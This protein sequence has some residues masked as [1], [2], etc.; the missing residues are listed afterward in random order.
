MG[1]LRFPLYLTF[2]YPAIIFLTIIIAI[3]SL[4]L[5]LAGCAVWKGRRI[6]R[7]RIRWL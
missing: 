5:T 7:P 4:V 6:Q 1:R 3:R 2:I